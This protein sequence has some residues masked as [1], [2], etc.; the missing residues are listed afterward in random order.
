MYCV[1]IHP[2]FM[3]NFCVCNLIYFLPNFIAFYIQDII[4]I[5]ADILYLKTLNI[6]RDMSCFNRQF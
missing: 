2:T 3:T 1:Y 4:Y 5:L 6:L